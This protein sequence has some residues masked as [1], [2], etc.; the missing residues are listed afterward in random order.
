[1]K[2]ITLTQPWADL[3][4]TGSKLFETRSWSTQYRGPVAIHAAKGFPAY[5]RQFAQEE[6]A[7]GRVGD[8][9]PLGAIVAVAV[10][11][12]VRRTEEVGPYLSGLE[13]HLG[14]YT[15]GRYAW[16]L[17]DVVALPA[18]VACRGALGLWT[19]PEDVLREVAEVLSGGVA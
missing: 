13:R 1:M 12:D 9:V 17:I 19:P 5:A 14:D 6:R 2:A 3:V 18:P 7:I 4:A 16:Q 15:P 11:A 8:H 10:I